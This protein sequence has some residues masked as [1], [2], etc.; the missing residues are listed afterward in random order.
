MNGYQITAANCRQAALKAKTETER[1][2]LET[3]ARMYD[4]VGNLSDK[5][6]AI[7]FDSGAFNDIVQGY[8]R[9]LF[10]SWEEAEEEIK[11][12]AAADLAGLFDTVTA[13]QAREHYKHPHKRQ[14]GT[15][16]GECKEGLNFRRNAKF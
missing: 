14:Q 4:I 5:E 7:L 15:L 13:A 6:Q 11:E 9:L 16:W 2:A 1:E 8:V 3:K 10:D 12:A